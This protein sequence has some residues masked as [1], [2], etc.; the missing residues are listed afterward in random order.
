MTAAP[1]MMTTFAPNLES[2]Q[3]PTQLEARVIV[4]FNL[5]AEGALVPLGSG[6]DVGA[7]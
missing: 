7:V 4:S 6:T 3:P 1:E 2:S 5:D